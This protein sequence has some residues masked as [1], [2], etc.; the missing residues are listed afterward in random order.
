MKWLKKFEEL[1]PELIRRTG[2]KLIDKGH[3]RKGLHIF[4][5][6]YGDKFSLWAFKRNDCMAWKSIWNEDGDKKKSIPMPLTFFYKKSNLNFF[7][8]NLSYEYRYKNTN[9]DT[10]ISD[11]IDGKCDL[12]F[13]IDFCFTPTKESIEYKS[14]NGV[15]YLK[16]DEDLYFFSINF[17]IHGT[18]TSFYSQ[19]KERL[20]NDS[21]YLQEYFSNYNKEPIIT[22]YFP[23]TKMNGGPDWNFGIFSDRRDA[24]KFKTNVLPK[25]IEEHSDEII[26]LFSILNLKSEIAEDVLNF[27]K[28]VSV[29]FLFRTEF[30]R[31]VEDIYD[32]NKDKDIRS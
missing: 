15:L 27:Y 23:T 29:N 9:P 19:L 2:I 14:N 20:N 32:I 1:S 16:P 26:E 4:D 18:L 13:N 30:P 31:I 10:L 17:K 5:K 24:V 7:P 8:V 28:K 11:W 25:A 12:S 21:T 3:E 22:I 6:S